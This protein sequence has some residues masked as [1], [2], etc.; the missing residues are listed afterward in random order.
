MSEQLSTKR[1][2]TR[3]DKVITFYGRTIHIIHYLPQTWYV[4]N[5]GFSLTNFKGW[6][7]DIFLGRSVLVFKTFSDKQR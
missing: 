2:V 5:Y 6:T 1:E 3:K 7:L 4:S